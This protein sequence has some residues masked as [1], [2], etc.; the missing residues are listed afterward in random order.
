MS[1]SNT[2]AQ[3]EV[4]ISALPVTPATLGM[5]R[6]D[7]DLDYLS[8]HSFLV[9]RILST[10]AG[11]A[12]V[13]VVA[14]SNAG[15]VSPVGTVSVSPLVNQID[16]N[17]N[18]TPHGNIHGL[19]YA[20]VQGGTDAII[21]DPRVGDIG[22]AVFCDRDTSGVKATGGRA[23]PGSRRQNSHADGVYLFSCLKGE[24]KQYIRFSEE[25]IE[26]VSPTKVTIKAPDVQIDASSGITINTPLVAVSGDVK[27]GVVS[28]EHHTHPDPQ[29]GSTSP[30]Q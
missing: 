18:A 8:A 25:G 24:P 27:A 14:V 10:V 23:N 1:G 26:L 16:G 22:I 3:A 17:G 29:G 13:Q 4:S 5:A 9:R 15:G 2:P 21:L 12:L 30:P 19:P 28:L 11:S 7:Q 6:P 20:R